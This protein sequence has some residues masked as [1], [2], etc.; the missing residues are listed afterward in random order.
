MSLKYV[1]FHQP[2]IWPTVITTALILPEMMNVLEQPDHV[3]GGD[4]HSWSRPLGP[5]LSKASHD[6]TCRFAP[7]GGSFLP[8]RAETQPRRVR[9]RILVCWNIKP[10]Q[11]CLVVNYLTQTKLLQ[12]SASFLFSPVKEA[13]S[14]HQKHQDAWK[15][16]IPF[17]TFQKDSKSID[18]A[19]EDSEQTL[20]SKPVQLEKITAKY[21]QRKSNLP[22]LEECE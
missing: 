13:T 8:V 9:S 4:T 1:H 21:G 15:V 3:K 16:S 14:R 5:F 19:N 7:S 20:L 17:W 11:R 6:S 12:W 2:C 22:E 18:I 10:L